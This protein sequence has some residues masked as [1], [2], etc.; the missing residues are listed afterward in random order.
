MGFTIVKDKY[1]DTQPREIV[2]TDTVYVDKPF[3]VTEIDTVT[4]RIPYE[5]VVYETEYD[6]VTKVEVRTDTLEIYVDTTSAPIR[7]NTRFLT[8][9]T[10]A[11]KFLE[12]DL[13]LNQLSFTSLSPQGETMTKSWSLNLTENSY[14]MAP[15]GNGG[16]GL[17]DERKYSFLGLRFKFHHS[18]LI[19]S[20]W[21]LENSQFESYPL[22]RYNPELEFYH[23]TRLS[24]SL[25]LI[26]G[27]PTGEVGIKYTFK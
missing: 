12:M 11:P 9:F 7:Y 14:R 27:Q 25:G 2:T 24:T 6:T 13:S 22:I 26:N 5:V 19:G 23:K 10:S 4:Q 1:I 16:V 15:D 17:E 21:V 20:S 18:L 8:N 3:K